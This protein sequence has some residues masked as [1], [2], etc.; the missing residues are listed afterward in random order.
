MSCVFSKKIFKCLQAKVDNHNAN[1]E[2]IVSVEQLVRV[3]KRGER[4]TNY[5]W[6][7]GVTIAQ[8]ALARVNLFLKLASE[9]LVDNSYVFQDTDILTASD[10]TYQQEKG[11]PFWIFTSTDFLISRNDLLMFHIT[12]VEA[13]NKFLPPIT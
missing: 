4:A 2:Q 1:Y 5:A 10:R 8:A 9:G 6:S 11:E 13:M 3:Y 7:P 12:D